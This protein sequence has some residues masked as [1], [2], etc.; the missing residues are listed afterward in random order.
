MQ[1][2]D[3][4]LLV[5]SRREFD[6][7][8]HTYSDRES[9]TYSA[10]EII[11][12]SRGVVRNVQFQL[13]GE[14]YDIIFR[15][16]NDRTQYAR[17][18]VHMKSS[19]GEVLVDSI[20]LGRLGFREKVGF[21]VAMSVGG[22]L[23][24]TV[25]R[26]SQVFEYE[27]E[28]AGWTAKG[29]TVLRLP[30]RIGSVGGLRGFVAS[31]VVGPLT[32]ANEPSGP[33]IQPKLSIDAIHGNS[34][35]FA[36]S[37]PQD[38]SFVRISGGGFKSEAAFEHE[39][40]TVL[41][42]GY[43]VLNG[44]RSGPTPQLQLIG[45]NGEV[46]DAI[47]LDWSD[48]DHCWSR[49][50]PTV[51]KELTASSDVMWDRVIYG[52][53]ADAG[54]QEL[55]VA[56]QVEQ[57]TRWADLL[58]NSLGLGDWRQQRAAGQA[59][60]RASGIGTQES[61]MREFHKQRSD[62]FRLVDDRD[63]FIADRTRRLPTFSHRSHRISYSHA[64]KDLNILVNRGM[65]NQTR[66]LGGALLDGIRLMKHAH[67]TGGDSYRI[68][69]DLKQIFDTAMREMTRRKVAFH[70]ISFEV[71][72]NAVF[73]GFTPDALVSLRT[74]A[75]RESVEITS[76]TVGVESFSKSDAVSS[77]ALRLADKIGRPIRIGD[78]IVEPARK[79][80]QVYGSAA[81]ATLA[82]IDN[83]FVQIDTSDFALVDA[84]DANVEFG[85]DLRSSNQFHFL[86]LGQTTESQESQVKDQEIFYLVATDA[87]L[88]FGHSA[89]LM[90]SDADGWIH[91][92]FSS[93]DGTVSDD[94]RLWRSGSFDEASDRINADREFFGRQPY[95]QY[96][97][98]R[99]TKEDVVA[100]LSY[101]VGQADASYNLAS[102][103]C[104]DVVDG[105]LQAAG[106][107]QQHSM[108]PDR[109]FLNSRDGADSWGWWSLE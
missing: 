105:A 88:G 36:F 5:W 76:R 99:A 93:T 16:M 40:G 10:P 72:R 41:S 2:Q 8:T 80:Y 28:F 66:F 109:T 46:L 50:D 59:L 67:W 96:L 104:D 77:T 20:E 17:L 21:Q 103:N 22:V 82:S 98:Y 89:L 68:E 101:L 70:P 30:G 86:A 106:I 91:A 39:G 95:T 62:K 6:T 44:D 75:P 33:T 78:T 37:S 38:G 108:Y 85:S 42:T 64:R 65:S 47:A 29:K 13:A 56:E 52:S 9:V 49:R 45:A 69:R 51:C 25:S 54:T 24:A 100:A 18:L 55:E 87:A 32:T 73:S 19:D 11:P 53:K 43:V 92:S 7:I 12:V 74:E 57:L 79:A 27:H 1:V 26:A 63:A 107:H 94:M 90:G 48:K 14:E 71:F 23:T 97:S 31:S 58:G 61:Q 81:Q 102:H 15:V 60:L 4:D 34:V 3:G 84:P 35:Q 83:V